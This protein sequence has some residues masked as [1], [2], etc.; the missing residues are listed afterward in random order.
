LF[1]FSVCRLCCWVGVA[2][3]GVLEGEC[4]SPLFILVG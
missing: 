3:V 4:V 1:D 2:E